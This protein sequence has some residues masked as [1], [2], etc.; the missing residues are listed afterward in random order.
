MVPLGERQ[1]AELALE[2]ALDRRA[3]LRIRGVP[4]VDCNDER[5]ARF[6]NV[7]PEMRILLGDSGLRV[8][9]EHDDVR[10]VDR[11]QRLDH[12]KFLDALAHL[13]AAANARGVDDRVATLAALEV[14]VDCI[15]RRAGLV[16]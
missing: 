12:G 10:I 16:E 7:A 2:L 6:E 1:E 5:T 4:L 3:R 15:A 14:E 13:S 9:E 11:L 8:D